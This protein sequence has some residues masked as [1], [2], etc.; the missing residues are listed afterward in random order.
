MNIHCHYVEQ[1]L[2]KPEN[3]CGLLQNEV[4]SVMRD[5]SSALMYLHNKNITHRDLKPENV[6][7]HEKN[8]TVKYSL[9]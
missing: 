6:V 2:K 7:L 8:E 5:I 4:M 9:Y 3:T 1:L